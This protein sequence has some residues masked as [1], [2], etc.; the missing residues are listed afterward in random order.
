MVVEELNNLRQAVPGCDVVAFADL[1][2][3]MVLVTSSDQSVP[4]EEMDAL[5]AEGAAVLGHGADGPLGL[6]RPGSAVVATSTGLRIFLR[7]ASEP[8]D[9]LCCMAKSGMDVAAFL[10]AARPCLDR[11]SGEG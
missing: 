8:S 4:R 7:A 11:I 6:G 2:T 3:Q 1:S 5:S 9:A 10:T